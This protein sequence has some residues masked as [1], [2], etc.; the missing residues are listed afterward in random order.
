MSC[1]ADSVG[2]NERKMKSEEKCQLIT[3]FINGK[4]PS[5]TPIVTPNEFAKTDV[6]LLN[7]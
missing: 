1:V 4:I 5:S 3:N 6:V 2:K 7:V